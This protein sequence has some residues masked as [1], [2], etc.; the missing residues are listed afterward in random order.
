MLAQYRLAAAHRAGDRR[1]RAAGRAAPRRRRATAGLAI[2]IAGL[3]A[4]GVAAS[5]SHAP[6]HGRN[7]LP[8]QLAAPAP[9]AAADVL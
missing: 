4:I 2:T 6:Q 3:V 5:L 9:V 7:T 1:P 8:L